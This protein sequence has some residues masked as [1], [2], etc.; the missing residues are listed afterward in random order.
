MNTQELGQQMLNAVKGYVARALLPLQKSI[1]DLEQKLSAIPAGTKGDKGDPGES[2]TGAPGKDGIDGKDADAEAI[3]KQLRED[4]AIAVAALSKPIDGKDGAPGRDGQDGKDGQSVH[5]DTV[6]MMVAERVGQAVAA[7]PAAKDGAPGRDAAALDILPGIDE[8]KSYP[9][10]TWASHNG[11]LIR[12]TRSTDPVKDGLLAAGWDVMVEG[13]SALVISQ[14]EDS[15]EL[16]VAAMLTSGVKMV[17]DFRV[18]AMIYREIWREGEYNEGD[19]VTWGGSAWHCQ[20][21]TTDKPGISSAWKLMVKH[22]A[23]GK[24]AGPAAEPSRGPVRLK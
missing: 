6:A 20:Q 14:G 17:S 2:I 21:K 9:R 11:G 18:P 12:A 16:S 10:G 23:P 4:L 3:I 5:P 22:G 8:G 15:R 19:V 1:S 7:L 13:V 24:D